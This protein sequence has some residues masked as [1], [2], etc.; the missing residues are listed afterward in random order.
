MA[1]G[2][3]IEALREARVRMTSVRDRIGRAVANRSAAEL[4]SPPADGGWSAGEVL[5]HIRT[6]EAQLVKALSRVERGEPVRMPKRAWFYRLPIS[7]VF[8]NVRIPAPGLV[9]PRPRAEIDP[10]QVI[11]DLV[12]T[13]RELFALADRFG[14]EKFARLVFPHFILGR[15][16]GLTWFQFVSRHEEKHAGQIERVLAGLRAA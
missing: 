14:E 10:L 1:T 15:F 5:D 9:R 7:P 16:T 13:R 2:R 8:W 12:V 11:E 4:L 3:R 6:A